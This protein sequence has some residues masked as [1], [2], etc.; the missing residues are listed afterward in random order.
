MG[1][2]YYT[3]I[4]GLGEKSVMKKRS[5]PT[6]LL[7]KVNSKL[8]KNPPQYPDFK[9][10]DTIRVYVKV[11]EGEK[12]RVQPFEGVVIRKRRA[13]TKS[14]FTVRKISSGV[15]VERVFPFFSPVIDRILLVSQGK[16]R[17]AKLYYLRGL[18]GR[19]GRIKSEYVYQDTVA[20]TE[21][22][23]DVSTKADNEGSDQAD[24]SAKAAR[25]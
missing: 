20:N 10:G 4:I 9:S 22:P 7:Q 23:A 6:K 18:R 5:D 16:V 1:L 3:P 2:V 15:G 21:D 12:T 24:V 8:V 14:T 11:K 13:G 19:A 17:R 25:A